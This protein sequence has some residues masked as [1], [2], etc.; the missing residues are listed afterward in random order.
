MLSSPELPLQ[1]QQPSTRPLAGLKPAALTA[2]APDDAALR[3]AEL[4]SAAQT[5]EAVFL[6]EMLKA[7]GYGTPRATFGGGAGEEAFASLLVQEQAQQL[8]RSGG[9]GIAEHVY[10][11]LL[12]RDAEPGQ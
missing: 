2:E 4:R 11:A 10:Q 9:L 5:F 1:L 6:A 3:E 8:A 12:A 7:A